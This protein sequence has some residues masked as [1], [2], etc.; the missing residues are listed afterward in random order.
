[1]TFAP[2]SILQFQQGREAAIA[3]KPRDG[4]KSKDWLA[5]WDQVFSESQSSKASQAAAA[6]RATHTKAPA[7]A[8][9]SR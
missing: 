7:L 9:A 4:R 6:P 2:N 1:M 8:A 3:G 5:G